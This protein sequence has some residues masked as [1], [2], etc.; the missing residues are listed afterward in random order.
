MDNIP[1]D[2]Q[3]F[4]MCQI[5]GMIKCHALPRFASRFALSTGQTGF[6]FHFPFLFYVYFYLH[7]IF[8]LKIQH[9][10]DFPFPWLVNIQLNGLICQTVGLHDVIRVRSA[11]V[12]WPSDVLSIERLDDGPIPESSLTL[13]VPRRGLDDPGPTTVQRTTSSTF[14]FLSL[15]PF[16]YIPIPFL[17]QF[18][19]LAF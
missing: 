5:L 11:L 13:D 8:L 12:G 18:S 4:L 17:L 15:S 7:D 1:E 9:L 16:S 3:T 2:L 19:F 10:K 6:Q 14:L